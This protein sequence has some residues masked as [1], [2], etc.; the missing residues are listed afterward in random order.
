MWRSCRLITIFAFC[1]VFYSAAAVWPVMFLFIQIPSPSRTH[2]HIFSLNS[3]KGWWVEGWT[4]GRYFE[5]V[6]GGGTFFSVQ[7]PG[8][9][10]EGVICLAALFEFTSF[11]QFSS[12]LNFAVNF[13]GLWLLL[14]V[15]IL[16]L[17]VLNS[18][19]KIL[20]FFFNIWIN[21]R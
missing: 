1:C 17:F 20:K 10:K 16:R 11:S 4:D 19:L 15:L 2:E 3:K 7:W 5:G 6:E 12:L 13:S 21:D 9:Q 18:S 14:R 8:A